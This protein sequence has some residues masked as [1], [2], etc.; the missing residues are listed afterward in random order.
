MREPDVAG[1]VDRRH[2]AAADLMQDLISP[3]ERA[4]QLRGGVGGH[5]RQARKAR[6]A[7]LTGEGM[8]G[9][10]RP[11]RLSVESSAARIALCVS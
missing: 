7:S 8:D 5:E 2:P 9:N 10:I 3:G 11:A 6:N 4:I 1:E